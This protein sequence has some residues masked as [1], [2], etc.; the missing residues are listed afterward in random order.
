MFP[1]PEFMAPPEVSALSSSSLRVKWSTAEGRG[2]IARGQISEYR[3]NLITEQNNNPY[4]PPVVS[5]VRL[6]SFS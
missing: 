6:K 3:V 2:V 5:Q 1:V 4:A